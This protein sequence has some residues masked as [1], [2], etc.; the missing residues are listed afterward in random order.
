MK[1]NGNSHDNVLIYFGGN[2]RKFIDVFSEIG[3]VIE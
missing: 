2:R 1:G 3:K